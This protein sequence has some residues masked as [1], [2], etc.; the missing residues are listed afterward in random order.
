MR[1]KT[2]V[3]GIA[4]IAI[5][6]LVGTA[7]GGDDTSG[8]TTATS[9]ATGTPEAGGTYRTETQTL[10]NTSNLDPTGEYYGWAWAWFQ[11]L[12]I[13]GLYNYN[14]VPGEEGAVPQPDLVTEANISE[15]GLTYEF[16]IRGDV[17]WAP[18]L[19]RAVT[20][21]DIEYAFE[22]IN[23]ASLAA[24][25]GN[26]YCSDV[27]EGMT[28]SEKKIQPVSGI[29]VVDDTHITFHLVNPTGDFLYRLAMPAAYP[30]P[31]EVAGCFDTGGDYG[32]YLVSN[33]GYMYFGADQQDI[34]S[35]DTLK[36]HPGFNLEKGITA[37][38]NPN[39]DPSTYDPAM[40]SNYLDG[41]QVAINSNVDDIFAK[42]QAGDL[43]GSFSD[44]PPATVEQEYATNP[45]LQQYIQSN[46]GARTWYITM[47][48]LTPPFDD[49]AVRRA[50]QW[51]VDKA[52]LVKGY[53]GSLH[54]VVATTD[55]PP[56]VLADTADYDPYPSEGGAGDVDQAMAAMKESKYDTDGDGQC[57]AP[58]CSGFLLLSS[59]TTP[60]TNMNPILVQN[61]QEIGL[62]P[63]LR[64]VKPDVVNAQ[65]TTVNKLVP[66][67]F[68]QGWQTDYNNPYGFGY[69]VFNAESIG[70]CEGAYDEGLLGLEPEQAEEC[71]IKDQFDAALANYPDG[72]LPSIDEKMAE[73]L[74]LPAEEINAC[75]A[76]MERILMEE[77]MVWVPWSWGKQLVFTSPSVTQYMFDQNAGDNG[78]AHIAV[79]NGLE[80]ENVA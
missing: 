2:W 55:T 77:G 51:V 15:D 9:G 27:I 13:R 53:G 65:A 6:A 22:R 39:S 30:Q 63:E 17:M 50:V 80:P 59:N 5:L 61:L 20:A 26:Y 48:L 18:P 33:S 28:C 42:I 46:E 34:T 73:C 57:D 44:T 38:R 76:D 52:A 78:W 12:M 70:S 19:D 62:Q 23:T 11:N 29:E 67:S 10:A 79:N 21:Q 3:S 64:E 69:F 24:Y 58:E 72:K 36:P 60:W 35:C 1:R 74:A 8:T 75:Y 68:G 54:A 16:T 14:H 31:E 56:S 49:P 37:V 40:F 32:P 43:D 47:N 7:C 25:Y 4:L 71:G 41:V 66:M 45:D